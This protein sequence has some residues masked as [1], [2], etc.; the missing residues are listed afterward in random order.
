MGDLPG[1]LIRG[2]KSKAVSLRAKQTILCNSRQD[3]TEWYQSHSKA[4]QDGRANLIEDDESLR[5][6]NCNTLGKS[7]IASGLK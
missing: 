2:P 3:V 4:V 5:G 1:S 7:H 6:V